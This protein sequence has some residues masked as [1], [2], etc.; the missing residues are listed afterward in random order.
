MNIISI[1]VN[2]FDP[3]WF[4]LEKWTLANNFKV[5]GQSDLELRINLDIEQ[6]DIQ[7]KF[8]PSQSIGSVATHKVY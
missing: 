6:M 4:T 8:R 3:H 7:A 5:K 2:T 1:N